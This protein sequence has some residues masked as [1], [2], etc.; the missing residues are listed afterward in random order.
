MPFRGFIPSPARGQAPGIRGNRTRPVRRRRRSE[1]VRAVFV[2]S[3]IVGV[4]IGGTFTDCVVV[5]D[6]GETVVGKSLST[7][8][9]YSAGATDAVRD[10]AQQH[11]PRGRAGSPPADQPLLPRLHH[12][13]EH[14]DHPLG[15]QDR[16]GRDPGLPRYAA[17]DAWQGHRRAHRGGGGPAGVAA[18]ARALRAPVP[19]SRGERAHGLQGRR[20]GAPRRGA[21]GDGAGRPG[22]SRGGVRR[23]VPTLVRGQRRPREGGGE[24]PAPAPPRRLR[25]PVE[26]GRAVRGG[27]RAHRHHGVQRLHRPRASPPTS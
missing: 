7:P 9:D 2:M 27:V 13:R 5:N 15:S 4:D 24:H 14:P 6:Q 8:P 26:R 10:A 23:R 25:H 17:D 20:R 1:T 3:Y 22:R 18:Q 16:H 19:G 11:R 12:R 21:G